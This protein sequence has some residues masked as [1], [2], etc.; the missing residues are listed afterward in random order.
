MLGLGTG[1]LPS[2]LFVYSSIHLADTR[3]ASAVTGAVGRERIEKVGAWELYV[4]LRG[5]TDTKHPD[6]QAGL[7]GSSSHKQGRPL[8]LWHLATPIF[9]QLQ[10]SMQLYRKGCYCL[11]QPSSS[12]PWDLPSTPLPWEDCDIFLPYDNPDLDKVLVSL[13]CYFH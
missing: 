4:W 5:Q 7:P 10:T 1:Q 11:I 12:M 8:A 9:S 6:P 3:R 2:R 13:K